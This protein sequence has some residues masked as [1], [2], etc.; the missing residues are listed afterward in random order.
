MIVDDYILD[1]LLEHFY[2]L[3]YAR[4][5]DIVWNVGNFEDIEST[6]SILADIIRKRYNLK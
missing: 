2:Q 4:N 6:V 3:Q 5:Y 1:I